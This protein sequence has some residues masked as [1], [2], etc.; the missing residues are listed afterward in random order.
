MEVGGLRMIRTSAFC[1]VWSVTGLKGGL[2][3]GGGGRLISNDAYKYWFPEPAWP[4][5]IGR[6]GPS[7]SRPARLRIPAAGVN[8]TEIT[9]REQH[10]GLW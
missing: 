10:F 9:D 6:S 2:G 4:L 5:R 8:G 1:V 7:A 3:G